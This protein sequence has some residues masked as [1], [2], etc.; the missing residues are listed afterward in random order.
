MAQE[1]SPRRPGKFIGGLIGTAVV[2]PG[3]GAVVVTILYVYR[4]V[5]RDSRWISGTEAYLLGTVATIC[6]WVV[7]A[8]LLRTR[9]SSV[10]TAN[11]PVYNELLEQYDRISSRIAS[12][13]AADD[14]LDA[15]ARAALAEATAQIAI[16]RRELDLEPGLPNAGALDWVLATGYIAVWRRIHRAQEALLLVEPI[17]DVVGTGLFDEARL[18]NSTIPGRDQLLRQLRTAVGVLDPSAQGYLAKAEE[19]DAVPVEGD[20]RPQCQARIVL[21]NTSRVINEFRDDG[22]ESLIRARNNL[23]RSVL[24]T[25]LTA[26][27]LLGLAIIRQVDESAVVA[28]ASFYLVG[29]ILGLFRQLG[30]ASSIDTVKEGDYGLA[31]ARLVHTPLFSGL[32]A[33]GG[34]VLVAV[35]G[36]VI[37]AEQGPDIPT[38]GDIF[39]LGTNQFGLVGAAVFGLT[40]NLLSQRLE[41]QAEQYKDD[42]KS[43]EASGASSTPNSAA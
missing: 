8:F 12:L 43:T 41:Q 1:R 5:P 29:G 24:V 14:Q 34:V 4:A 10:R 42:L 20:P 2:V 33:V 28:M 36:A 30:Q 22:R 39:N 6:F 25:G 13:G 37:P 21:R 16:C 27:V 40:P 38:L 31:T 11:T 7:L 18:E 17:C 3:M 9:V 32:A 35:L 26:Y 19:P 15:S 23:Y